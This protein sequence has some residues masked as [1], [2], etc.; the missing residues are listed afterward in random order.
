ME[1]IPF[2]VRFGRQ[3]QGWLLREVPEPTV[4]SVPV[5][6]FTASGVCTDPDKAVEMGVACWLK[7]RKAKA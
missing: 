2:T 6:A 1:R 5:T 7:M 3:E 4:D